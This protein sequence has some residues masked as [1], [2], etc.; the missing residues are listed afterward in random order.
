MEKTG[1][2]KAGRVIGYARVSTDKQDVER[3][4]LD[5]M[6]YCEKEGVP[7]EKIVVETVSSRKATRE[8]YKVVDS[9]RAGDVLVVTELSRL[10]RSSIELDEICA[11]VIRAGASLKSLSPECV[12][13]GSILGQTMKFALGISAQLERDFISERTKSALK[14]RKEQGVKLGRPKGK[15]KLDERRG[16]IEKYLELGINKSNIAKLLGCSRTALL[17]WLANNRLGSKEGVRK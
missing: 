7:L 1:K 6:A 5:I 9:L 17:N 15:S 11:K 3:Q 16:D 8:V 14:A 10:A 4:K 13:D 2:A 12:V